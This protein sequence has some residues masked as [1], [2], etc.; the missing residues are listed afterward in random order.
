MKFLTVLALIAHAHAARALG[1]KP[2]K[3][4][5]TTRYALILFEATTETFVFVETS[6][7]SPLY[8]DILA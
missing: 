7:L 1:N 4:E 2:S 5:I 8:A 6:V 3:M